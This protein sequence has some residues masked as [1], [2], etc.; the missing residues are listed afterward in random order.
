MKDMSELTLKNQTLLRGTVKDLYKQR[1][2]LP[3]DSSPLG[4]SQLCPSYKPRAGSFH[5]V[6]SFH[7][8]LWSKL[9]RRQREH[10]PPKQRTGLFAVQYNKD[11]FL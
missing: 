10:L 7:G 8:R 9:L 6:L 4:L 5:S 3:E 1:R 11:A 2:P